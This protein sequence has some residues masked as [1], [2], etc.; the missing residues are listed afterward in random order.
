MK[1]ILVPFVFVFL[2]M[3]CKKDV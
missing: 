1:K 2:L 3:A